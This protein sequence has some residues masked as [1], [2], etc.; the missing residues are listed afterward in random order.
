[1]RSGASV[2]LVLVLLSV[3]VSAAAQSGDLLDL[4]L[5]A[6][7]QTLAPDRFNGPMGGSSSDWPQTLPIEMTLLDLPAS[8]HRFYEPFI[9]R[10]RLENVGS[11][12]VVIPWEPDWTQIVDD[13]EHVIANLIIWTDVGD[14]P[15]PDSRA[16]SGSIRLYGSRSTPRTLKT[17]APGA[18]VEIIIP[19]RWS[20][21]GDE[22]AFVALL[23]RQLWVWS[24]VSMPRGVNG[25][26]TKP[27]I[28]KGVAVA[29]D[30][31]LRR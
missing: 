5:A 20:M 6:D 13:P 18:S 29:V 1:M 14:R 21:R 22:S 8:G 19:S 12:P 11:E 27:L 24:I 15:F 23:P 26:R 4:T 28:S 17:L 16:L 30:P 25:Q 9:Y 31:P 7:S 3:G 10:L 2:G